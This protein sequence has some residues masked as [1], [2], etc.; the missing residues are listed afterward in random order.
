MSITRKEFL[1]NKYLELI[2]SLKETK[3]FTNDV[4][5]SLDDDM[6]IADISYLFS[7]LFPSGCNYEDGINQ[8]LD[9]KDIKLNQKNKTI[10]YGIIIPFLELFK[11]Y[12]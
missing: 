8:L 5:P 1:T 3:I 10:A 7:M 11:K 6:D 4:L 2:Q 9:S 12:M